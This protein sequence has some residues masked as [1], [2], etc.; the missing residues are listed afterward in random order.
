MT[1]GLILLKASGKTTRLSPIFLGIIPVTVQE[2]IE[3]NRCIS[4]LVHI[5]ITELTFY[6]A[7]PTQK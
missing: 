5:D 7:H 2:K 6:S 3:A 1:N 4:D